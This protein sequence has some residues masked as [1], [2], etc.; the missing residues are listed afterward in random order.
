MKMTEYGFQ[1]PHIWAQANPP[2]HLRG[3][4][5]PDGPWEEAYAGL[6]RVLRTIWAGNLE[7]ITHRAWS[8]D[9]RWALG[10]LEVSPLET[11][12]QRRPRTGRRALIIATFI[13]TLEGLSGAIK[14]EKKLKV[15]KLNRKRQNSFSDDMIRYVKKKKK[16]N[17][18]VNHSN[19]Q[20]NLTRL[21]KISSIYKNQCFHI[22]ALNNYSLDQRV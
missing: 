7:S 22:S 6:E 3:L 20:V 19:Q 13:H 16:K 4:V 15:S 11:C 17:Y 5:C 18:Q 2:G 12:I 9:D 14:Q 8:K 10:S 1:R 21:L